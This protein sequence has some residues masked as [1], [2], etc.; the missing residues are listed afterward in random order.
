MPPPSNNAIFLNS[1]ANKL[2]VSVLHELN[3]EVSFY[4]NT[5]MNAGGHQ[6]HTSCVLHTLNSG[7]VLKYRVVGDGKE[8]MSTPPCYIWVWD[9]DDCS[10]ITGD[11]DVAMSDDPVHA[12]DW[13]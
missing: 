11:G 9:V 13:S 1:I 7:A 2:N 6:Y 5:R 3:D 8:S 4:V 12:G 10:H